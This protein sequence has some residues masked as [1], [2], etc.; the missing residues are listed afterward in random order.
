VRD[1][2]GARISGDQSETEDLRLAEEG[3]RFCLELLAAFG[4][5]R[6]KDNP[7]GRPDLPA[8]SFLSASAGREI[9]QDEFFMEGLREDLHSL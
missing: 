1:V 3:P 6:A 2:N 4:A 7:Q 8:A 5:T 9:L